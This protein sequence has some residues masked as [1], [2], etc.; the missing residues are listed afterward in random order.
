[1]PLNHKC[2]WPCYILFIFYPSMFGLGWFL[3]FNATF[4]NISVI[5]WQSVLLV[6]ETGVARRSMV[7]RYLMFNVC[8]T[9]LVFGINPKMLYCIP[10]YRN[11]LP[12]TIHY[13]LWICLKIR[14]HFS[15]W[16]R[17]CTSQKWFPMISW[18][19][20]N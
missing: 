15:L 12:P 18:Q 19:L 11:L 20:Q 9:Y 8:V 2:W 7:P 4:N 5:L 3:V 6:V 17:R 16:Q 13:I 14:R 10:R 1:M